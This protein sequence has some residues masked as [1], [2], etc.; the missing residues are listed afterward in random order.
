M[1]K[2]CIIPILILVLLFAGCAAPAE[3]TGFIRG[4]DGYSFQNAPFGSSVETLS[5]ALGCD[6]SERDNLYENLPFD[7]KTYVSPVSVKLFGVIGGVDAQF[8][9]DGLYSITFRADSETDDAQKAYENACNA[10]QKAFGDPTDTN[11]SLTGESTRWKDD[12]SKTTLLVSLTKTDT[13]TTF[14]V[15]AFQHWRF[16]DTEKAQ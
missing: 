3:T 5:K 7:S 13:V 2:T 14:Q 16:E 8:A 11:E 6:M 4:D 10:F 1:K 12:T 15:G 9:D